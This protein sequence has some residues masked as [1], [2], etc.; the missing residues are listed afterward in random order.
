MSKLINSRGSIATILAVGL[1][2]AG[3]VQAQGLLRGNLG[4]T[5]SGASM[6]SGQGALTPRPVISGVL[7]GA[8]SGSANGATTANGSVGPV[9]VVNGGVFGNATG[10]VSGS[11]ASTAAGSL[12]GGAA[13]MAAIGSAGST[14]GTADARIDADADASVDASSVTGPAKRVA[15]RTARIARGAVSDTYQAAGNSAVQMD[16]QADVRGN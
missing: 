8:V 9:G 14:N 5:T 12:A 13:G 11:G 7:S 6:I 1:S 2:V 3:A 4:A 16:L 10:G 15:T